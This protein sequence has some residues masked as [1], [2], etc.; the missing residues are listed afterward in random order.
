MKKLKVKFKRN[1]YETEM[2]EDVA[3]VYEK[4][5]KVEVVKGKSGR[6]PKSEG[7]SEPNEA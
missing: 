1:G 7:E 5:G 2:N 6:P 3:K 4:K